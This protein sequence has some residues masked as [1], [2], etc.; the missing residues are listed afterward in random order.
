MAGRGSL[1]HLSERKRALIVESDLNRLVLRLEMENLRTA[2]GRLDKVTATV[3]RV[4]PW[5]LPAVSFLGLF[6]G[7]RLCKFQKLSGLGSTMLGLIPTLLPFFG[8][9]RE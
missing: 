7:K 4:G 3:R 8:R 6:A 2:S 9:K 1:R 5:L